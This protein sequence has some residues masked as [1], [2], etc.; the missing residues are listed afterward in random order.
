MID[1]AELLRRYADEQSQP[2]FTE[3]VQRRIDLVYRCALYRVGGDTHLAREVTQS[4]F[5]DLARKSRR[6]HRHD[7]LAAWLFTS[8][9]YAASQAMRAERRRAHR[10]QKVATMAL[11][12]PENEAD[13]PAARSVVG[14]ALDA[15]KEPD[16]VA[17]LLRYF[18]GLSLAE[19]G[20]KSGLSEDGARKRIDRALVKVGEILRRRGITSTAAALTA[21][22]A[23]PATIAAPPGLAVNVAAQAMSADAAAAAAGTL[24]SFMSTTKGLVT[25]GLALTL[26]LASAYGWRETHAA[27]AEA[28]PRLVSS[29]STNGA[30]VAVPTPPAA[31]SEPAPPPT[32]ATKVV[33]A[34]PA[35]AAATKELD[36]L[37][38]P[39]I[40]AKLRLLSKSHL[41]GIY[42]PLFKELGLTPEQLDSLKDL[43]VEKQMIHSD[44]AR[45]ARTQGLERGDDLFR[46]AIVDA[47]RDVDAQIRGLIGDQGYT[48]YADFETTFSKRMIVNRLNQTIG[49]TEPLDDTQSA[50]LIKVLVESTST[51]QP[52][53]TTGM[54]IDAGAGITNL[55]FSTINTK[56]LR[57][58]KPLLS[59]AQFEAMKQLQVQL[60]KEKQEK[61]GLPPRNAP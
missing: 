2:A 32:I 42:A 20:A 26:V 17:L 58:A 44:A 43:L 37:E 23:Q 22:L 54:G 41:D 12:S 39:A 36:P 1:D 49:D 19:I 14:S 30:T 10:Q 15:L 28:S 51:Q 33:T 21:A 35:P 4:V 7:T 50:Q 56:A 6:L 60:V 59:P 29:A 55:R 48:A 52:D 27:P 57:L 34:S 45:A 31:P 13:W 24:L 53:G 38:D 16:R 3:L 61:V 9:R 46:R 40:R 5:T 8:T 18:E 11:L 47:Q 25:T